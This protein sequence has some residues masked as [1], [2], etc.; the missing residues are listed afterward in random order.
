MSRVFRICEDD[1]HISVSFRILAKNICI[2]KRKELRITL[3]R[4]YSSFCRCCSTVLNGQMVNIFLFSL[5]IFWV[6]YY[7]QFHF[8]FQIQ[9]CLRCL[10]AYINCNLFLR[11]RW[12]M[13]NY[14]IFIKYYIM[15]YIVAYLIFYRC[16]Y[17][18]IFK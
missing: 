12:D 6:I 13:A 4:G 3:R 18:R 10:L 16:F 2:V 14:Y 9:E 5:F 1:R 17:K 11:G 7:V 15:V 8:L